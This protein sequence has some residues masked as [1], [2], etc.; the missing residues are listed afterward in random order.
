ML[1][2]AGLVTP[3]IYSC[4]VSLFEAVDLYQVLTVVNCETVSDDNASQAICYFSAFVVTTPATNGQKVCTRPRVSN[5][6]M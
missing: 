2:F 1:R 3:G 5:R 6:W 4:S